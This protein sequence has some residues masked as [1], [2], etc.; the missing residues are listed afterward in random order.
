MA[1]ES[2]SEARLVERAIAGDFDSFA[3][4][5]SLHLDEIFRYI[6]FRI[7]DR[8]EAED[9]TEQVFLK[10]WEALPNYNC[11]G[12][13]FINWLY[14]I[15]HNLV[16][17]HHRCRRTFTTEDD[18]FSEG[19][20][21]DQA[22]ENVLDKVIFDEESALLAGAIG[23]LPEDY[24]QVIILRFVER[25]GYAEIAQILDKSE[26]ACRGIQHRALSILNRILT[27]QQ[28]RG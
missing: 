6:Y 4:L 17:D 18:L 14:R 13:R 20:L 28:E 24:Q 1:N 12:C 9:M 10:A 26:V 5:Y 23:R 3:A 19:S 11:S 15:S 7:L 2:D 8:Q 21:P 16:V 27:V 22:Q 25:L